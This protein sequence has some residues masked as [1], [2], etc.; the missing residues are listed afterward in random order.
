[1]NVDLRSRHCGR[2]L[3]LALMA[4]GPGAGTARAQT[5]S[6]GMP[7]E[8]LSQYSSARTLGLGGAYVATADDPL[9]VVW[10]PAGLSTMYQN[11]LRFENAQMFGD[12]SINAFSFA[13]PGSRL[14]SFGVS[15]VTLRS[16]DFQKT[17]EL[18]DPLGTFHE[19]ESA[20]L[21]SVSKGFST[22]LSLGANFKLVQQSLEAFSAQGMGVDVGGLVNLTPS[23]R[24][25]ASILNVSGPNIRL[26]DVDET[27][28]ME[29]RGGVAAQMLGGRGLITA[30]LDKSQDQTARVHGGAEYWIQSGLALRVGLDDSYG[31]GG[32]SYRLSPQYQIDYGVSDHVLGLSHRVGLSYKFGG[33]FASSMSDPEVF[34]PTGENAVTKIVLNAHTKAEPENWT[35]SIIDKSDQE[36]RRFGG[37]G[38]PPAHVLWDGKGDAGLP[39][40]DGVYRYRLV[41]RDHQDREV[42]SAVHKVEISGVGPQGEVQVIPAA[43]DTTTGP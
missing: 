19:S 39:L 1:M 20:Y 42:A 16:A 24:I 13:V 17:N 23:I 22:R 41:V 36:V 15:M 38:Q 10:N 35:L 28:P 37:K 33:F 27:Y 31:T 9:G 26:R 11:E 3:A 14:P 25:G 8:W 12:A 7:G 32:F 6:G 5:E 21:F 30:Q 43:G 18:N 34:S 40:P 29:F 2:L 4:F